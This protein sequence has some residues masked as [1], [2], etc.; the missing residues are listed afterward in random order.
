MELHKG[1][2]SMNTIMKYKFVIV[3]LLSQFLSGQDFVIKMAQITSGQSQPSSDSFSLIA[4]TSSQTSEPSQSDSFSVAQGIV[5]AVQGVYSLPPEVS[6]FLADT[7]QKDGM[8]I[9]VQGILVDINGIASADLHLQMGGDDEP[10]VIPMTALNDS[11]FEVSIEDSLVTVRNFR[12]FIRGEDNKA[13]SSESDMLTPSVRFDETE[14][15]TAIANSRYP[16]G[17]LPKHWRIVSFPGN[18]DEP[19]IADPE[20]E[21]GHVFYEWNLNDNSW[22]VPD[23]I[24][25]GQAYWFKHLY[26]DA[27]PFDPDSGTAIPLEPFTITLK[28]GWN[29]VGSP[30]AFPVQVTADPEV[31]SA[32][33]FYGDSTGTD[34]WEIQGYE[35]DPWAGYAVH[36]D[37]E[38]ATLELLPFMDD[39]ADDSAARTVSFGWRL[40]LV[41]NG[42]KYF[43]RT[44]RIGR[45]E[46]ASEGKDGMDT[47]GLPSL[48]GGL[49]LVMSINDNNDYT[50][51]SDIRSTEE[52]NG[53][54]DLRLTAD[55]EPGPVS[56]S[57]EF[58]GLIPDDL[59][60]A[61]VDIQTRKIY[62]DVTS[63]TIVIDDRLDL[64]YD[65]KIAAGDPAY[66]QATVLKILADIPAEFALSQNYPNPFNPVTRLNYTLPRR[67]KVMIQVYNILGQEVVTLVNAEQHYGQHT[68]VWNG[69]DRFG[70]PAASGVYFTELRTRSFR[71]AKKM[72]LL[73]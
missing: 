7:V 72:L 3:L 17:I 60:T 22:V 73:K 67:S 45:D 51:S 20:I 27:L 71:Q 55:G 24:Y 62:N 31:V 65:F 56:I 63:Q 36:S 43:D 61:L 42:K 10:V 34:G 2:H 18:L 14:L 44:G 26:S 29:M 52:Q 11:I 9:R 25:M 69:L 59:V 64:A 1:T 39:N 33:Y 15:S 32:I 48:D 47:P 41:V 5:S 54:W 30:F 46:R 13:Y 68:A 35:M 38:G 49:S 12:A 66:V 6:A 8:P 4:S 16:D 57:A 50:F 58:D 37:S 40:N 28:Q 70:K 23:S 21:G 53:V 19:K